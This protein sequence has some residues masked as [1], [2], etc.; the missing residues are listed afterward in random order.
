MAYSY[1]DIFQSLYDGVYFVDRKRRITYWNPAAERITGFLAG[2]VIGSRCMDDILIH[3]D[4]E[5]RSLCKG[6]CLLAAAMQDGD[7]RQAEVYLRHKDG[8]RVPVAVRAAPLRDEDGNVIGGVELFS[9]ISSQKAMQEKIRELEKLAL[10]DSLTGLSNRKH[11]EGELA[12]RFQ[13]KIR[14]GLDFGLLFM[15]I[16]HFKNINDTYG[17]NGGDVALKTISAT[18]RASARSYD[19]VGRWGG[20]EF[21]G[22][23]RNVD[24]KILEKVGDRYRLLVENTKVEYPGTSFSLTISIGATLATSEDTP[25]SLLDRADELLYE[26]KRNGRNRVTIDF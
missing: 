11:V 2:E 13:E 10:I 26:S 4:E 14:Y 19:L 12:A 20:E 24:D 7:A 9:D 21:V 1:K 17:H 25:E 22:I 18:F 6:F 23:I 5:G 16:D 15:D 8:H 3:I